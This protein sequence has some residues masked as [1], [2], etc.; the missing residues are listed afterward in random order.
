MKAKTGDLVTLTRKGWKSLDTQ[1]ALTL[2]SHL[3]ST[4]RAIEA[5]VVAIRRDKAIVDFGGL[6]FAV[7]RKHL[8]VVLQGRDTPPTPQD[9]V[10]DDAPQAL[11]PGPPR[12]DGQPIPIPPGYALLVIPAGSPLMVG[13]VKVIIED[14]IFQVPEEHVKLFQK[15]FGEGCHTVVRSDQLE[16]QGIDL[17]DATELGQDM[18]AD[19]AEAVGQASPPSP[20]GPPPT[21]NVPGI[22]HEMQFHPMARINV[23]QNM[24]SIFGSTKSQ[25]MLPGD[26]WKRG[27]EE[28][29]TVE[30][31][32]YTAS[33][34]L[35][36]HFVSKGKTPN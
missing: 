35:L 8:A 13:G 25:P 27:A 15:H 28:L 11:P 2:E 29:S 5:E 9:V 10:Q 16:A 20:S 34:N 26:E 33:L 22:P 14:A 7:S 36:A 18:I 30:Q 32:C 19:A 6:R 24:V 12:D 1:M 4:N 31:A 23:A 3:K 17:N 21:G